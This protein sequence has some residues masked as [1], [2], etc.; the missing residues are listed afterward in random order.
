MKSVKTYVVVVFLLFLAL[1]LAALALFAG[2]LPQ[3]WLP[4]L[5][6]P[7]SFALLGEAMGSLDGLFSSIAIVL[8]MI[9][10]LF[11]GREL[12]ASTDAQTLQAQALALQITQ[13]NSANQLAAYSARLNYLASEINYMES[14][15]TEMV[16]RANNHKQKGETQKCEDLWDIIRNTREKQGRYRKQAD[17]IDNSI[18]NLLT[19]SDSEL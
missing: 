7:D 1:W 16:E 9:A 18:Q 8:G 17:T 2:I 11:Q 5:K 4:E 10:I 19:Q 12:K 13:Q 15:I 14:K 6:R 3:E